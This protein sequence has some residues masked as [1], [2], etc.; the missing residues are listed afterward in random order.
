MGRDKF[1]ESSMDVV[2][3]RLNQRRSEPCIEAHKE[4]QENLI[5]FFNTASRGVREC[6]TC[7]TMPE[8]ETNHQV[9]PALFRGGPVY[10]VSA[11]DFSYE[12][13]F[14]FKIKGGEN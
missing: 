2:R 7:P 6:R 8:L 1:F 10:L 9:N 12:P 5:G 4:K 11:D 13:I 14:S 3:G